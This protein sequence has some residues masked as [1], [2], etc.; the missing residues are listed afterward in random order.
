MLLIQL[1]ASALLAL[2]YRVDF[3]VGIGMAFF[4]TAT[5]LVPLLVLFSMRPGLAGWS[6][7]EALVVVGFFTALKGALS[8][9]LQPALTAVV[10]HVR[11]G[12]LDFVLLKPADSQ[13]LVS[14]TK[15]DLA[16]TSDVVAGTVLVA[17]GVARSGHVPRVW[18][19]AAALLLVGCAVAVLYSIFILAVSA[20]FRV[21]KVDNL[22]HLISS[23]YDAARWPADVF[24][25]ALAVL[26][27]FVI[28][29][30][31]MTTWPA[32]ALLGR[33]EPS[34]VLV[35]L[36]VAG[37]FLLLSRLAWVRSISHYTSAGG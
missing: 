7:A 22:A 12:T 1:R 26:F 23:T 17:Y 29:L 2:Q 19:A 27:T 24:R 33:L 9:A 30:A 5:A 8:G 37:A 15:F 36:A 10:D 11:K 34:R 32:E 6:A 21:V 16:R 14:T 18:E 28:P 20:A 35:A 31:L 13:F 4:W 3:F 25:G